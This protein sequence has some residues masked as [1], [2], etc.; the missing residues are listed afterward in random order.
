VLFPADDTLGFVQAIRHA[1]VHPQFGLGLVDAKTLHE[2]R[3]YLSP[4][5]MGQRFLEVYRLV[6]QRSSP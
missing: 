3:A 4:Q 5:R 1:C 6:Q 2:M